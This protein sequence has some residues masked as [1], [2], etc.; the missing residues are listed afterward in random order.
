MMIKRGARARSHD[1]RGC[2]FAWVGGEVNV[3]EW[4]TDYLIW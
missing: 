4:L 2:S 3:G 1:N